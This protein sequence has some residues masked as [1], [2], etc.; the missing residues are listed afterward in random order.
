VAAHLGSPAGSGVGDRLAV[1]VDVGVDVD[2]L[3]VGAAL[4]PTLG[5]P[6]VTSIA[7]RSHRSIVRR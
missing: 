7:A 1:D 6:Q 3:T 4:A 5:A 2:A